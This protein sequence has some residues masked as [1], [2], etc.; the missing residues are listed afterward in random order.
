[1]TLF[2]NKTDEYFMLDIIAS[3][4]SLYCTRVHAGNSHLVTKHKL[5]RSGKYSLGDT[6]SP[7]CVYTHTHTLSLELH[8]NPFNSAAAEIVFYFITPG[9]GNVEELLCI[10]YYNMYIITA[11]PVCYLLRLDTKNI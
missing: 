3:T 7:T 9:N 4:Y 1:M 5:R 10:Y 2:V 8:Q 6:P 11:W